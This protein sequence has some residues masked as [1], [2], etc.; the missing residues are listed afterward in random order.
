MLKEESFDYDFII[1]GSGFGG[2]ISAMRLVEKGYSVC[3]IEQG[4][5]FAPEDFP[6][7]NWNLKKY[8]WFPIL[9]FFG[10]QK[11]TLLGDVLVLSGTGVGGG[12]LVYANTLAKPSDD[13]FNSPEWKNLCHWKSELEPHYETVKKMLGGVLNPHLT[14]ADLTLKEFAKSIGQEHTFKPTT[15]AVNFDAPEIEARDPYFEGKGPLRKG[16]V[17]CGGCMVGCRYNAKNTLDKNYLFFAEK[18]GING[19]KTPAKV[20]P[21]RRV[22]KICSLNQGFEVYTEQ[23]GSIFFKDKK[24]LTAKNIV[25]A[26]G[27]LGTVPLLLKCKHKYKTLP[28][29]SNTLGHKVRTNGEVFTGI[30]SLPKKISQNQTNQSHG[31][32]IG[33]IIQAD[34]STSIEPVRYPSGSNFMRLISGPMVEDPSNFKRSIKFALHI[35]LNPVKCLRLFLNSEWAKNSII[36]LVM[37]N[38]D[39]KIQLCYSHGRNWKNLFLPGIYSEKDSSG[40]GLPMEIPMGN[41]VAKFFAKKFNALP[42]VALTQVSVNI[43]TT[44]H[45]LGGCPIGESSTTGVIDSKHR[46]FNYPNLYV[47]DGSVIPAN[48]GVNPSFTIAA[49]AE[50]MT[51]FIPEKNKHE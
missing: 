35:L 49:L 6:K 50:R 13:F 1:V 15:V 43:C 33:S 32:A 42:Q 10:I 2:S 23:T 4:K 41:N 27:V 34:N 26:G 38:I 17:Q 9:R 37:Q 12:S 28:K 31:I 22:K 18:G 51:S 20:L 14:Q 29:I 5:R 21:L 44:A 11:L 40:E 36:F 47:C 45:I 19:D 16:C 7:T 25:V 8:L 48:I 24:K 46:V 39:N 30:T 3:V